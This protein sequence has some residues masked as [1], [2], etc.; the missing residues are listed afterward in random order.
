[1][2]LCSTPETIHLFNLLS[3]ISEAL[4]C[5]KRPPPNDVKQQLGPS[6]DDVLF[7]YAPVSLL[8]ACM[9]W[10][11]LSCYNNK[12]A[13]SRDFHNKGDEEALLLQSKHC[14]WWRGLCL[15][16]PLDPMLTVGSVDMNVSHKCMKKK[17]A[18][19][20]APCSDNHSAAI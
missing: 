19:A 16:S 18:A 8:R 1:M 4:C 7:T 3:H 20:A 11:L 9:G 5:A 10:A 13:T 12:Y 14:R 17:T 6:S 2:P 15:L